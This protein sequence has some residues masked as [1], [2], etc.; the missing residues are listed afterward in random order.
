M[1]L[2]TWRTSIF[3]EKY[4]GRLKELH[5]GIQLK[6]ERQVPLARHGETGGTINSAACRFCGLVGHWGNE[7]PN[8]LQTEPEKLIPDKSFKVMPRSIT[9]GSAATAGLTSK[10]VV[11]SKKV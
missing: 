2:I 6:W 9:T 10:Q 3:L 8:K 5:A 4:R 11:T 7:C 1:R